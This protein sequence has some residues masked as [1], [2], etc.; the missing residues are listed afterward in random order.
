MR[1]LG[2]DAFLGHDRWCEGRPVGRTGRE[3]IRGFGWVGVGIWVLRGG[4][5][6][7]GGVLRGIIICLVR[8]VLAETGSHGSVGV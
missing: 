8:W 3:S 2:P 4:M 7:V 5:R 6:D 1:W